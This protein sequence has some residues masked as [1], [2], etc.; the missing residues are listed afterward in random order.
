MNVKELIIKLDEEK[1]P[2]R[3]YSIN[4][5][6]SSD[7]YVLRQVYDYWEF[8]YVDERGNQNNDYRRFKNEEDACNYLLEQ[9]LHQKNM[10]NS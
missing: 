10:S 7:I 9:L 6:L 3:W 4:G 8:F 2:Q 1:I 5:N